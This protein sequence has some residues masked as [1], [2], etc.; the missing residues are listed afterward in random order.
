MAMLKTIRPD[1]R[2]AGAPGTTHRVS[3]AFG[4]DTT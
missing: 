3:D 1:N 4:A 2:L